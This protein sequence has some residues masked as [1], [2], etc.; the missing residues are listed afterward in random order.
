MLAVFL[1]IYF[2]IFST[3][4]KWKLLVNRQSMLIARIL[5]I[6][7]C[8]YIKEFTSRNSLKIMQK[9]ESGLLCTECSE[10]Q[11]YS[12]SLPLAADNLASTLR[13]ALTPKLA[14]FSR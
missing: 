14:V 13:C 11:S 8:T 4:L 6:K 7:H 2:D 10:Y 5:Q 12:L 1:S 3:L 9:L